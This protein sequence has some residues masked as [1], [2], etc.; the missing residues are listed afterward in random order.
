MLGVCL[1]FRARHFL[2]SDAVARVDY[3][4]VCFAALL[5]VVICWCWAAQIPPIALVPVRDATCLVCLDDRGTVGTY[6]TTCKSTAH[7]ACLGHWWESDRTR[8]SCPM[9]RHSHVLRR[10]M[11][12]AHSHATHVLG[13]A[14]VMFHTRPRARETTRCRWISL[15]SWPRAGRPATCDI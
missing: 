6:C 8:R 9:C 1:G 13:A 15:P 10:R 3:A 5:P 4:I 11:P 12:H 2:E 14:T 7:E